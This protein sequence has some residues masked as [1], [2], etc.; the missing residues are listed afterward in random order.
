M[1]QLANYQAEFNSV[2]Q[3]INSAIDE[4]PLASAEQRKVLVQ[5]VSEDLEEADEVLKELSIANDFSEQDWSSRISDMEDELSE[6]RKQ[7]RV[8]RPWNTINSHRFTHSFSRLPRK[9]AMIRN[10]VNSQQAVAY[11]E[12]LWQ[13]MTID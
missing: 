5:Q 6:W 1:K 12:K 7:L 11:S 3:R 4:I 8:V 10:T 2:G 9:S 13:Q